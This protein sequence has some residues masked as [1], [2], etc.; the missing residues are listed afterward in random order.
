VSGIKK[1]AKQT[2]TYGVS[3]ILSRSVN[4]LLTPL[5]TYF[6]ADASEYGEVSVFF[7]FTAFLFV[8]FTLGMETAF[9]NFAKKQEN[10]RASFS[11]AFYA[12]LAFSLFWFP[13]GF[14][15]STDLAH[16]AEFPERSLVVK[17][18]VLILFFDAM[19][20]LPFALLRQQNKAINYVKIKIASTVFNVIMNLVLIA[21]LFFLHKVV[22]LPFNPQDYFIEFIFLSNVLSSLFALLVLVPYFKPFLGPWD[23][24]Q[25]FKMLRY[26]L[27]LV[28]VG[29]AGMI[30]ETL[31]RV[32]LKYL[33]AEDIANSEVG[34][35]N[36]FYK[37]SLVVTLFIQSFR[38]A[39][40]PFFFGK[41][42][43]QDAKLVYAK[44]MD[45]FVWICGFIVM[46]TIVFS[47]LLSKL[48]IR[49][50][51]YF[52]G[53]RGMSV[54]PI[55]L[56]ANLFLGVY[57]NLSIWYKITQKTMV[58]G[59]VSLFGALLTIG[60]NLLWIPT[61]GFVGSAWATLVAYFAMTILS[62]ILGSIYYPVPYSKWKLFF[63][64]SFLTLVTCWIH[65]MPPPMVWVVLTAFLY[66]IFFAII[67][68]PDKNPK[69]ARFFLRNDKN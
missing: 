37:I 27:P 69:F 30:N 66:L 8:F 6:L 34:I 48:I 10:S 67:E 65:F 68:R 3:N 35:Y 51:V 62:F 23:P 36:A 25:M 58:G 15:F 64:F 16:M 17:M 63:N 41:S 11:N 28:L 56:L 50:E 60:F 4:L 33:L 13:V 20:A 21:G 40:E 19:A 52:E 55:L 59:W 39:A 18:L 1:L 53:G 26:S 43:D 5:Y 61:L 32:L 14:Y 2:L 29:F 22:P 47:P 54:V 12:L 44:V 57:Y 42:E 46:L 9:F 49:K 24:A 45:Y 7:V 31:D 38:Y